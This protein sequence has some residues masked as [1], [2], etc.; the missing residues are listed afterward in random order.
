VDL[1]LSALSPAVITASL[2]MLLACLAICGTW[3]W[4]VRSTGRT[5]GLRDF[6]EVIRAFRRAPRKSKRRRKKPDDDNDDMPDP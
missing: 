2:C 5:D 4:I 3:L 6:A 1:P